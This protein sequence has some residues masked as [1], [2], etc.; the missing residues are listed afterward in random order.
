MGKNKFA[1]IGNGFLAST[2]ADAYCR[3]AMPEYE[4][5]AVFGIGDERSQQIAEKCSCKV[6]QTVD[7]LLETKPDIVV[8][9]ASIEAV[10]E[11]VIK[12]LKHGIPF[13][14]LS[15]GAFV[16]AA[17]YEKA[18]Q[19]ARD[20][21]TRIYFSSGAIGGF[22]VMQT[23]ALIGGAQAELTLTREASTYRDTPVFSQ[24]VLD[25][26]EKGLLFEGTA[27]E[28]IPLLP[29]MINI[30]VATSLATIGPDQTRIR[31]YGD[32]NMPNDDDVYIK[33]ASDQASAEMKIYSKSSILV[34]WS[35]VSLLNNLVSPVYFY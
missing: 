32:P 35:V 15:I 8:E 3:G 21:N 6:A 5:T 12:V 4:L 28:A 14:A 22:D 11:Y 1:M 34:G 31:I 33:V 29:R 16:D 13:V 19:T 26:G 2:I 7:E 17:F 20:H 23:I 18:K 24:E 9:V 10:Q 25:S 30:G 27:S